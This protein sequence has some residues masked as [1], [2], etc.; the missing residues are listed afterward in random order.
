MAGCA[1]AATVGSAAKGE[2]VNEEWVVTEAAVMDIWE[3]EWQSVKGS[4]TE[5]QGSFPA[6]KSIAASEDESAA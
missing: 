4:E 3:K 2:A 1:V 6:E 5:L